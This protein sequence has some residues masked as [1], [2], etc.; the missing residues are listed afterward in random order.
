MQLYLG[1][2]G[3]QPSR[4]DNMNEHEEYFEMIRPILI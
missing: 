1:G 3:V 4:K 2:I